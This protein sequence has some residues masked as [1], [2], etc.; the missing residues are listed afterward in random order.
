MSLAPWHVK[1]IP[2]GA[3]ETAR[4]AARR[5][6]VSVGQWLNSV[7]L[8]QAAAQGVAPAPQMAPAPD[9]PHPRGEG[10][11]AIRQRLDDLGRA[12]DRLGLRSAAPEVHDDASR[13]IADAIMKL[14]GRLDQ[15]L[16]EGRTASSVLE[17]RVDSVDRALAHL[18]QE[19]LRASTGFTR[20]EVSAVDQAVAEITARQRALDGDF[21]MPPP[22]PPALTRAPQLQPQPAP[23]LPSPPSPRLADYV[24][25]HCRAEVAVEGLR[26]DLAEIGRALS[27]AMPRRAVEALESEVRA[28]A[29]RLDSERR[30][31]VDAASIAGLEQGLRDVRDAL[32]GL[33][34][35]ESLVG[36]DKAL[37]IL[38]GKIDQ[39]AA[40]RQDPAG[41]QQLEAAVA[42]LRDGM[43]R[44]ASS[45]ALAAL[46]REVRG[47]AER[48]ERGVPTASRPDILNALD[49]RIGAIADAIEDV[50][51][52]AAQAPQPAQASPNGHAAAQVAQLEQLI[53][54]LG[55]KIEHLQAP[56]GDS[57]WRGEQLEQLIRSL[58]D[59]IE[60]LQA[61]A[62]DSQ[63]R[64][65][66]L[67][68]LIRSLGDKIERL[69]MPP[70]DFP[71]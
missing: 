47:L 20:G 53:Q 37:K 38:A 54:S 3:R 52:H 31:G 22:P 48:I 29:G 7:I 50:R 45:D 14:N 21:A 8:G 62:G 64:G 67:E 11:G 60:H 71:S 51:R 59:K 70:G 69:Q 18:T 12:L 35:A 27:E 55:D 49:Q 61:P 13:R 66:Q 2:P 68:Q 34:P 57:Q 46:A 63:W 65:E 25:I 33:A 56:P 42:S 40:G 32:R 6:G 16:A 19:R 39:I 44:V 15:V 10:L 5:S 4:E 28:L 23:P 41:L 9:E 36:F 30:A 17:Q 24:P 58:G 26:K 1:G 43:G